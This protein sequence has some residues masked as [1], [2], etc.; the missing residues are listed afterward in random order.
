MFEVSPVVAI[1]QMLGK[2][3]EI[4][5]TPIAEKTLIMAQFKNVSVKV[6]IAID[7]AYLCVK[8]AL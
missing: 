1:S 8:Y 4:V 5:I 2:P 6:C 7:A 3:D